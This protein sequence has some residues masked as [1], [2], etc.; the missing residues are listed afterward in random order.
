MIRHGPDHQSVLWPVYLGSPAHDVS[1]VARMDTAPKPGWHRSAGREIR[2]APAVGQGV[3]AV[4]NTEK[5]VVLLGTDSGQVLWDRRLGGTLRGGPLLT[6]DRVYAATEESPAGRVYALEMRTGK[7]AWNVKTGG[8]TASLTLAQ[9]RLYAGTEAGIVLAIDAD[10]GVV[11]W[12]RRLSGAVRAAPVFTPA[13]LFVV[14]TA[15]SLYLLDVATGEVRRRGPAPGAVLATPASDSARVYLATASGMLAAVDPATLDTVWTRNLGGGVFGSPALARDT[16]Y[17]L[18]RSGRLVSVP[19]AT[20]AA[21]HSVEL[22]IIAVAG[23]T[24][25]ATGVLVA[26]VAGVVR[27]VDPR[28][29]TERWR[30]T[31]SGPVE[32]PALVRDGL[33]IVIADRGQVVTYR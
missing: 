17:A 31:V 13:G 22:G 3:I 15:D 24:P 1:A 4:S 2:G 21:A 16:L 8:I 14:T 26:D 6:T 27:C 19:L 7:V 23:P 32:Q 12:R 11:R 5:T 30:V 20:P 28:T 9:G 33:L 25:L 29:G 10:S 18:T